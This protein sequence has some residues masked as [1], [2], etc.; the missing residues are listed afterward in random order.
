MMYTIT[1]LPVSPGM[2][3]SKDRPLPGQ[4]PYNAV[5]TIAMHH[6]I[7][8]R[9]NENGKADCDHTMLA[10]LNALTPRGGREKMD[11]QM[12]RGIIGLKRRL[13]M[14]VHWSSQLADE[15]HKP[16]RKHYQKRSVFAKQVDD[17]WTA[18][19]VGMALYSRSNSGYKYL[20]TV[21]DVFSKYGWIVPLKTKTGK[22]LVVAFQELFTDSTPPSRLWTDNGTEFYNQHVKRVLAA[23]NVIL[24]STENEEKSSVVE[25]WNRTMKN[26]M[27]N[28]FTANNT[29]K[30]IDVLP[31]MV[32]KYNS[33]YHRS[34]KLKPTDARKPANYK[35]VHNALYAKVNA[36]KA[37]PPR[38][39]V[40]D[41]VRIVRKK[42]TFEKGFTPNWTCV[43]YYNSE[44]Y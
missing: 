33:T 38:F 22:E 24:Y 31:W 3:L 17:I 29:P 21:I 18:D 28:Y 26:I 9:D 15:L 37:T 40:G 14:G 7:C 44:S 6:D 5:D 13:E 36:R 19:L 16:V 10:E 4:E 42:G 34:I 27:W 35:R 2:Q 32:G 1:P 30:Y 20:L 41:K 8:Y 11:R 23:I 25:R 43:Y 39:H 12:V